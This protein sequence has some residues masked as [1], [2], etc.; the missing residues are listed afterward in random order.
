MAAAPTNPDAATRRTLI[1]EMLSSRVS[2]LPSMSK[3]A[4]DVMEFHQAMGLELNKIVGFGSFAVV[5]SATARRDLPCG[6]RAG[7]KVALKLSKW[8]CKIP[9]LRRDSLARQAFVTVK[10]MP[11]LKGASSGVIA[12][13]IYMTDSV[14]DGKCFWGFSAPTSVDGLVLSYLTCEFVE[15][16]FHSVVQRFGAQWRESAELPEEFQYLVLRPLFQNTMLLKGL[17]LCVMDMKG[18]NMGQREDG[19]LVNLDLGNAVV[20]PRDDGRLDSERIRMKETVP[21][22][23]CRVAS[24]CHSSRPGA[25]TTPVVSLRGRKVK[26]SSVFRV[27]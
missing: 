13:P 18:S 16:S 27:S 21:V 11:R 4:L 3:S 25:W 5:V 7:T 26:P 14:Q 10:M 12:R 15:T 9:D 1:N 17:G 6:V 2:L 22:T 20:F 19:T 24:V 23:Y 8:G